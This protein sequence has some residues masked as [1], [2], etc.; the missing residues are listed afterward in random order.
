MES[1]HKLET[2]IAG[3]YSGLPHLPKNVQKW[4]GENVW[5]IILVVFIL[6]VFG[7]FSLIAGITALA[8]LSSAAYGVYGAYGMS[9]ANAGMALTAAW[10]TLAGAIVTTVILG[11]AISPLKEGKKKGWDLIFLS[12]IAYLVITIVGLLVSFNFG[13]IIGTAIGTAIGFYFLFEIR[14]HYLPHSTKSHSHP[15]H[16]KAE[17]KK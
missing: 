13:G 12:D 1:L 7:I 9:Q 5:W 11:L 17:E 14:G 6:S 2:T 8:T 10:I 4:I 15:E 16:K 3:W